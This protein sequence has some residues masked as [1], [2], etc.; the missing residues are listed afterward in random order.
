[1]FSGSFIPIYYA[2]KE[3][4]IASF[5]VFCFYAKSTPRNGTELVV[6]LHEFPVFTF[7]RNQKTSH[8]NWILV[9]GFKIKPNGTLTEFWSTEPEIPS[10][11]SISLLQLFGSSIFCTIN[12]NVLRHV[13]NILK[14]QRFST[15]GFFMNQLPPGLWLHSE[16]LFEFLWTYEEIFMYKDLSPCSVNDNSHQFIAGVNDTGNKFITGV[17]NACDKSHRDSLSYHRCQPHRS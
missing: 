10:I 17:N 8:A 13:W 9:F 1:M 4:I 15:S 16:R 3:S 6:S 2:Y 11:P 7:S 14:I 5:S 12:G